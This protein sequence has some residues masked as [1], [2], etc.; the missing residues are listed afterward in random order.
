MSPVPTHELVK[1]SIMGGLR[2]HALWSAVKRFPC[3]DG[4][5]TH[6]GQFGRLAYLCFV[7]RR[8][9]TASSIQTPARFSIFPS[10]SSTEFFS[11]RTLKGELSATSHS[12]FA[13]E[14][15]ALAVSQLGAAPGEG[16]TN[17]KQYRTLGR[18]G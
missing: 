5:G 14:A 8:S 12:P 1:L 11:M 16:R 4:S 6:A 2:K 10:R 18:L 15:G 9:S 17:T 7:A 13:C 3:F